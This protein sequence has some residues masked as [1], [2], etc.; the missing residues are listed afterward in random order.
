F[1]A[2]VSGDFVPGS[3]ILDSAVRKDFILFDYIKIEHFINN[4]SQVSDGKVFISF[5]YNR[6]VISEKTG[7]TIT[8]KGLTELI[9]KND[10]GQLKLYSMK[11]PLMFGLSDSSE[12]ATGEVPQAADDEDPLAVEEDFA[13][14]QTITLNHANYSSVNVGYDF[15]TETFCGDVPTAMILNAGTHPHIGTAYCQLL[16]GVTDITTISFPVSGYIDTG[17][18]IPSPTVDSCWAIDYGARG[19]VILKIKSYGTLLIFDYKYQQ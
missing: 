14:V 4:I 7:Q 15:D 10:G 6:S 19:K 16:S 2:L 11:S 12:I 17:G 3:D 9:L 5:R 1:M 8:G 18:E 13:S